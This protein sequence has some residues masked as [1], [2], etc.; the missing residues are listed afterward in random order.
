MVWLDFDPRTGHEQGGHRPALIL[1]ARRYN[2]R[3][4]LALA[5]PI[6]SRAKG[7]PWETPL[8]LGLP[9]EGVVLSDHFKNVDWRAR[10]AQHIGRA[11]DSLVEAVIGKML[12]VLDVEL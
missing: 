8:P 11:P 9:I 1:S 5:C 12:A 4:G 7:S 6:T 2:A 10:G 3:V